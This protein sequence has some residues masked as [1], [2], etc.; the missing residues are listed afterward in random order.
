MKLKNIAIISTLTIVI[1]MIATLS[2]QS[3]IIKEKTIE[4]ERSRTNY[5]A[6]TN[7]CNSLNRANIQ[8]EYTITELSTSQD[9]LIAKLNETRKELKI[10]DKEIKRLSYLASQASKRDTLY[11][12]DTIFKKEVKIDTT[13]IDGKWYQCDIHLEYPNVIA[14]SP[15]FESEKQIITS[16]KRV[17]LNPKKCWLSRLFQKKSTIIETE[18]VESNPYIKSK[19]EKFIDIVQ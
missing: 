6:L 10:K 2:I 17:I 13:I 11:L 16:T 12:R 9:S 18:V 8:Y 3:R 1:G 14:V 15:T 5:I 7:E 4:L 19:K